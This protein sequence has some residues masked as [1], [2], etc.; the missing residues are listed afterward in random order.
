MG[1]TA[2][3]PE[4]ARDVTVRRARADEIEPCTQM[5]NK[6]FGHLMDDFDKDN[7]Y[8]CVAKSGELVSTCIFTPGPGWWGTARVPMAAV[9]NVGTPPEH[10]RK[11]YAGALMAGV[12]HDFRAS[13]YAVCPLWPFSFQYYGKFGWAL[14]SLDLSIRI[15]PTNVKG[16][17]GKPTGT[18]PAEEDDLPGV[19]AAYER[20]AQQHNA[21]T[22]R[23]IGQWPQKRRAT[24]FPENYLVREGAGG[25]ID[26]YVHYSLR[27][28]GHEEGKEAEAREL[29]ATDF[30]AER[31][32]VAALAEMGEVTMLSVLLPGD[33]QLPL[34]L[35][36]SSSIQ[37]KQRLGLR[38][39]DAEA[40][41]TALRPPAD[42]RGQLQFEI[43][44]PVVNERRALVVGA[45]IAEGRVAGA[46]V[47]S[48]TLR[49]TINTFSQLFSGVVSTSQAVAM[50]I[51]QAD[52]EHAIHLADQLLYGRTPF[53]SWN[54]PG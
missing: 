40:A 8:T 17:L 46:A 35:P 3:V 42:L 37:V 2:P 11:G 44:D 49:C 10:Q 12:V 24:K 27:N 43:C 50:G 6:A 1:V 39:V 33:S 13:G 41:L 28:R 29:A 53:R 34:S 47:K 36:I 14:G 30:E 16:L 21:C 54:E 25:Q 51:I 48:S 23:S 9:G 38:V 32:L 22:D 4:Y 7:T 26:G 5:A 15:K 18:R 19:H 31:A 20:F 52:D 45:E